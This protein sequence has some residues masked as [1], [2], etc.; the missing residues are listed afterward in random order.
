MPRRRF[1]DVMSSSVTGA[2]SMGMAT[3]GNP[4]AMGGGAVLGGVGGYFASKADEPFDE[5]E[6]ALMKA[7]MG[8]I[9]VQNKLGMAELE[10]MQS[11]AVDRRR[12]ERARKSFAERLG[13][14]FSAALRTGRGM[15]TVGV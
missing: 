11:D 4:W 9:G 10:A 1:A 6:L 13:R 3:G 2:T 14:G 7:Q 12:R 15:A 8:Q 5:A